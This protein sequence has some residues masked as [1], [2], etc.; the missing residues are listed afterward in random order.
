MFGKRITLFRLLGF[1]VRVDQSWLVLAV[2]VTW[3]LA[4]GLFPEYLPG[5]STTAYWWMGVFG[6]AGFFFSILFHEFCHSLVARHFGL[7]ISGIT[8]FIFGGVAEM[9]DEPPSSRTEFLMAVAGPLSSIVLGA[10]F[11]GGAALLAGGPF[12]GVLGYLATINWVLAV[13]NLVPAFPLDGGRMLRATLWRWS[14]DLSRATHIASRIGSGFGI[15]IIFVGIVNFL[16]GNLIG[17]LWQFMIGLFLRSAAEASY[18]QVLMRKSL[19]GETVEHF[20]NRAP[21]TVPPTI[22][23]KELVENYL[24]HYHFRMFPI[25]EGGKLLGCVTTRRVKEIPR[26]EWGRRTVTEI[27]DQCTVDSAVA[28]DAD[29]AQVL[30][31]MSRTGKTRFMVIDGDR[32]VGII[33]I[34][35]I[36][37]YLAA[38][39]DRKKE[40]SGM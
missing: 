23:V 38:K 16:R 2:L 39:L 25:M 15:V 1:E 18:R 37:G 7:P 20:M 3:S 27:A 31:L 36:L 14:G 24:Y 12:A 21:V 4:A 34:K 17:G 28:P 32:L 6:A 9:N 10:L 13:F 30:G 29:A 33:S 11:F 5:L 40:E 22:T 19:E 26:E 8:L 35:D